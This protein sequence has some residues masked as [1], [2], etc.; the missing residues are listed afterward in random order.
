MN[1]DEPTT[2]Y[3]TVIDEKSK[4]RTLDAIDWRSET[5]VALKNYEA[6]RA[7]FDTGMLTYDALRYY[8]YDDP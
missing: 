6:L 1:L 3:R 7:K 5:E 8:T 4:Q 2:I